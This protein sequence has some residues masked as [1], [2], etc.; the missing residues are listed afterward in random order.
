MVRTGNRAKCGEKRLAFYGLINTAARQAWPFVNRGVPARG[1]SP[2][3]TPSFSPHVIT[4]ERDV[5]AVWHYYQSADERQPVE[6]VV[7]QRREHPDPKRE[8]ELVAKEELENC[9]KEMMDYINETEGGLGIPINP[10][11]DR[12]RAPARWILIS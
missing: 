11:D 1:L 10:G 12:R 5:G 4:Q 9:E 3:T 6:G 8:K 7:V 2:Q